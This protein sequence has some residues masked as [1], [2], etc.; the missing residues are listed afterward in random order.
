MSRKN[1]TIITQ[2][3]PTYYPKIFTP[4]T[5]QG[6]NTGY[7]LDLR[8]DDPNEQARLTEIAERALE[9]A[10]TNDPLFK[11]KSWKRPFY[12]WTETEQADPIY[13]GELRWRFKKNGEYKEKD[14]GKTIIARP[15]TVFDAK[16]KPITDP[17][18]IIGNGSIVR[19]AFRPYVYYASPTV[20]G[21]RFEL[22]A[23]QILELKEWERDATDYGFD[24]AADSM[25]A[26]VAN[27]DSYHL[28]NITEEAGD[29]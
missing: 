23:V 24:I 19:A 7:T 25:D 20:H 13:K 22:E 5:Y 6:E 14:T 28:A 15:P 3:A 29:F 9:E 16:G 18:T 10:K 11:G 27:T 8:I 21:V 4:G 26:D 1:K 2:A 17:N 12:P